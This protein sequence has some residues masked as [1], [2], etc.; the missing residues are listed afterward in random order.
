MWKY[1]H[2]LSYRMVTLEAGHI[3]QNLL[4]AASDLGLAAF[5]SG[6]VSDSAVEAALRLGGADIAV[7]YA[8]VVGRPAQRRSRASRARNSSSPG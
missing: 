5:P 6:A 7:L 2:P 8:V 3:A 1:R 4:V